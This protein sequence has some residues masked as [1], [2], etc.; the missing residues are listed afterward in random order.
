MTSICKDVL[1]MQCIWGSMGSPGAAWGE[2]AGA[3]GQEL[4]WRGLDQHNKGFHFADL[5]SP[6][7]L[8]SPPLTPLTPRIG[9]GRLDRGMVRA[10]R[11][12]LGRL[13]P[14]LPGPRSRHWGHL[15]AVTAAALQGRG[16]GCTRLLDLKPVAQQ[17][18]MARAGQGAEQE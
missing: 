15:P 7:F 18:E 11:R 12:E 2:A 17:N 13:C 4:G 3:G 1:V 10:T 5:P 9:K 16:C 14:G 6:S 8:A